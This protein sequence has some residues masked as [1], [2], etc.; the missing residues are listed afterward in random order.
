MSAIPRN[1][2]VTPYDR[3]SVARG[4]DG[5]T[6]PRSKSVIAKY[7]DRFRHA[8][9]SSPTQRRDSPERKQKMQQDFWWK[10]TEMSSSLSPRTLNYS[11]S[12][13]PT[14]TT[15]T[16][17]TAAAAAAKSTSSQEQ[18]RAMHHEIT[19]GEQMTSGGQVVNSSKSPKTEESWTNAPLSPKWKEELERRRRIAESSD[20]TATATCTQTTLS[21]DHH[22]E[23]NQDKPLDIDEK[24]AVEKEERIYHHNS[25][26]EW[27][28][29][30]ST[31][32][33]LRVIDIADRSNND[34]FNYKADNS[35]LSTNGDLS[36]LQFSDEYILHR[37]RQK[38]EQFEGTTYP[39][40]RSNDRFKDSDM[41]WLR[42]ARLLID[43]SRLQSSSGN[44]K[45]YTPGGYASSAQSNSFS[46]PS[47]RLP[48]LK[49]RVQKFREDE[50]TRET[51]EFNHGNRTIHISS[52]LYSK[53]GEGGA[54]VNLPGQQSTQTSATNI[55]ED[56]TDAQSTGVYSTDSSHKTNTEYMNRQQELLSRYEAVYPSSEMITSQT[57][58]VSTF[59]SYIQDQDQN[60]HKR[61][62]VGLSSASVPGDLSSRYSITFLRNA[63]SNDSVEKEGLPRAKKLED[64]KKEENYCNSHYVS[65]FRDEPKPNNGNNVG[66][67]VNSTKPTLSVQKT[68]SWHYT[69]K[70]FIEDDT[71]DTNKPSQSE[72]ENASEFEL[73]DSEFDDSGYPDPLSVVNDDPETVVK[74]L[75]ERLRRAHELGRAR[76]QEKHRKIIDRS[77][78]GFLNQEKHEGTMSQHSFDGGFSQT[79]VALKRFSPSPVKGLANKHSRDESSHITIAPQDMIEQ[80]NRTLMSSLALT[81]TKESQVAILPESR[82]ITPP[83]LRSCS[84][85][86]N[87]YVI[88]KK[89]KIFGGSHSGDMDDTRCGGGLNES[90]DRV[91]ALPFRDLKLSVQGCEHV[92]VPSGASVSELLDQVRQEGI[93][94][95][96]FQEGQ[97]TLK[98]DSTTDVIW[99][100]GHDLGP[101]TDFGEEPR[102]HLRMNAESPK[103]ASRR[104]REETAVSTPASEN[105]RAT[106]SSAESGSLIAATPGS[107]DV[108][109]LGPIGSIADNSG[110]KH[111]QECR[112]TQT[113]A[114]EMPVACP[115]SC[116]EGRSLNLAASPHGIGHSQEM[117]IPETPSTLF[118]TEMLTTCAEV[119]SPVSI[120]STDD[121]P[122][123][124][125]SQPNSY[126]VC[127]TPVATT[128][129]SENIEGPNRLSTS[130][131]F[132]VSSDEESDMSPWQWNQ[133]IAV[134]NNTS[135]QMSEDSANGAN[136]DIAR[137]KDSMHSLSQTATETGGGQKVSQSSS[138]G[139]SV[140]IVHQRDLAYSFS[141]TETEKGGGQWMNQSSSG[142][143]S[144]TNHRTLE[145][146]QHVPD[147]PTASLP[148][149]EPQHGNAP[150]SEATDFHLSNKSHHGNFGERSYSRYL[151]SASMVDGGRQKYDLDALKEQQEYWTGEARPPQDSYLS[152]VAPSSLGN[153]RNDIAA[154]SSLALEFDP[155]YRS[156][157]QRVNE[158]VPLPQN[159]SDPS[160]E[161]YPSV[162]DCSC[163][164]DEAQH[165]SGVAR[166]YSCTSGGY[167]GE[168]FYDFHH[169]EWYYYP[170]VQDDQFATYPSPYLRFPQ[171]YPPPSQ[172][173]GYQ[174]FYYPTG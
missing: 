23:Y 76:H 116:A 91:N 154:P 77:S 90:F 72:A 141:E 84:S 78:A 109:V 22:R 64:A 134:C 127:T 89:S 120:G 83:A 97:Q 117:G 54:D 106:V 4:Q 70:S 19:N 104:A 128:E 93:D 58:A 114:T 111:P 173:T 38:Q 108:G 43:D 151:Q 174:D 51:Q 49:A 21:A 37:H 85:V 103:S 149:T 165:E 7:I 33:L 26:L 42:R 119:R 168:P 156:L 48:V 144:L 80:E 94:S 153:Y 115:R 65:T 113:S 27:S 100:T 57:T 45:A 146:L 130:I 32:E 155:V 31:E 30:M 39:Q 24:Q 3:H 166:R 148:V 161:H 73:S 75:R 159:S 28:H 35:F 158:I 125:W 92:N 136:V 55:R 124:V 132:D 87:E 143:I 66:G 40:S 163:T 68:M 142:G 167:D 152:T 133:T 41:G 12:T 20:A 62:H 98:S 137:Q 112:V 105:H 102:T 162:Q 147:V 6:S 170:S 110:V 34:S 2:S 16:S 36:G 8:P 157:L 56:G 59:P 18:T 123:E 17:A 145:V 121:V 82:F 29:D 10:Q 164:P 150:I 71:E 52:R 171:D 53:E 96:D 1:A 47:S 81:Q 50:H 86:I 139:T 69:G 101:H 129:I 138:N 5:T 11:S 126:S 13:A 118:S 79:M 44:G 95:Q 61:F 172:N 122:R 99:T 74:H 169:P 135:D 88:P 63:P 131:S 67:P 25:S 46:V 60:S 15:T 160:I 9:P 107:A 140:D 14:G